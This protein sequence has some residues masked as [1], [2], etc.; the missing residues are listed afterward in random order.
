MQLNVHESSV[1]KLNKYL[2]VRFENQKTLIYVKEKPFVVCKYLFMNAPSIA[3]TMFYDSIDDMSKGLNDQLEMEIT[4]EEVGL[5]PEDEFWGHC[6]NLQAWVENDYDT[7]LLH[8]NLAFQLLEKLISV[9]DAK[10]RKNYS[11]ELITRFKS[12]SPTVQKFLVLKRH[13]SRLKRSVLRELIGYADDKEVLELLSSR[14]SDRNDFPN[15]LKALE[16]LLWIDPIHRKAH[17]VL[18][19]TYLK[20]DNLVKAKNVLKDLLRLYPKD[21][22]A[23][24][25][26]AHIYWF[27]EKTCK[28]NTLIKGVNSAPNNFLSRKEFV[29]LKSYKFSFLI[30]NDWFPWV[31]HKHGWVLN[32]P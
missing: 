6:S 24:R 23:I 29:T 18:A 28:A 11:L 16:R 8:R 25:F 12:K 9:G 2:S 3:S 19:F 22:E 31:K 4:R 30:L 17:L 14:F 26:L 5:S 10:A 13:L 1:F 15:L 7:R 20:L 32:I 27:E 21:N